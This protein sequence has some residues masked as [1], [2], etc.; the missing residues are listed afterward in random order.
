MQY[1]YFQQV[2]LEHRV[3]QGPRAMLV[4]RDQLVQSA[5]Q[6]LLD[7]SDRRDLWDRRASRVWMEFRANQVIS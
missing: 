6:D 7:R 2:R 4:A 3:R 1:E 5:P